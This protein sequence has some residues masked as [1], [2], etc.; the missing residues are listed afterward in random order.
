[1]LIGVKCQ[2]TESYLELKQMGS[3]AHLHSAAHYNGSAYW[4]AA[5]KQSQSH[6]K[7]N[8]HVHEERQPDGLI[9]ATL[10]RSAKHA[11]LHYF[12]LQT[13]FNAIVFALKH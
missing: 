2:S 1:M 5:I 12:S 8:A 7:S 3:K 6:S 4:I 9:M 10:E 11:P 13:M